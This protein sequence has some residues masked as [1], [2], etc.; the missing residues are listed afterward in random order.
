[1][2][3]FSSIANHINLKSSL[4]FRRPPSPS[5]Q[6]DGLM[7]AVSEMLDSDSGGYVRR[8]DQSNENYQLN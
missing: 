2:I 6:N 8:F 5:S 7:N 4:I 1:M 3:K